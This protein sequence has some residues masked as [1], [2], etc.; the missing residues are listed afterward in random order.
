MIWLFASLGLANVLAGYCSHSPFN[1]FV[2]L[3]LLAVSVVVPR[4]EM[5]GE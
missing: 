1:V 3:C 4:S 2:G 5:A